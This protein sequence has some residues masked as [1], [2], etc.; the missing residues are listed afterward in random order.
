MI[1]LIKNIPRQSKKLVKIFSI[2][3]PWGKFP[4]RFLDSVKQKTV[5]VFYQKIYTD[6][7]LWDFLPMKSKKKVSPWDWLDFY[8]KKSKHIFGAY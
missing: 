7:Q 2:H 5:T 1:L 8:T 3:I 6:W 4:L